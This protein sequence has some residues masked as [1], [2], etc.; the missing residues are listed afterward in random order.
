MHIHLNGES[1]QVA[2]PVAV[3]DLLSLLKKDISKVAVEVNFKVVP[4]KEHQSTML[5]EGD[6]VEI[7]T[8]VG[9]G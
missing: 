5:Q 2:K 8:L 1:Y 4:L 7:V 6:V 3:R 9:G